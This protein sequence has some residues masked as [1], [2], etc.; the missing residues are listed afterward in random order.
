MENKLKRIIKSTILC[1]RFPFLYPRNRFTGLHYN[2][3]KIVEF[4]RK[5]W[6]YTEDT[7][8]LRIT[9]DKNKSLVNY[10]NFN[11]HIYTLR[12]KNDCLEVCNGYYYPRVSIPI[13]KYGKG[14]IIKTGWEN[15]KIPYLIVEDWEDN[16]DANY[17]IK[18]VHAKWL[19]R[20]IKFLDWINAYPLQILHC[21]PSYTELDAMELGWRKTF[22][23]Q[24][25]K[26]IRTALLKK[27]WKYLFNYRI[28]QIKEKY[29]TLRWYD[30]NSTKE[31]FEIIDKY[32]NLSYHTCINC[33]KP[34]TKISTGWICPYCDN[35]IGDRNYT[36]IK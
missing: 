13:S 9:N 32:E 25:C 2:N 24:M 22:G 19:Q 7:F 1:I 23:I 4:H 28:L 6:K 30:A 21:I 27:G 5:W 17:F 16:P 3:W 8:I 15:K 26:E 11:N 31:I 29:G 18:I 36:E 10:G 12:I 35:C 33:G 20:C 14:K 34:A